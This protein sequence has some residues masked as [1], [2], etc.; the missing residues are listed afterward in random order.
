MDKYDSIY[1]GRLPV[2]ACTNSKGGQAVDNRP[3]PVSNIKLIFAKVSDYIRS[4]LP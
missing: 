1:E 3:I 4:H 2:A